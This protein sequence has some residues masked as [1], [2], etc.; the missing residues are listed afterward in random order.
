MSEQVSVLL[1]LELDVDQLESRVA[2]GTPLRVE[3]YGLDIFRGETTAVFTVVTRRTALLF[4]V[5]A[6]GD[7]PR[8]VT[9]N[10]VR[11]IGDLILLTTLVTI[12]AAKNDLAL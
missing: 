4:V 11:A 12:E 6:C 8:P 7:T 5:G 9:R 2:Q 1:R 10:T 3:V